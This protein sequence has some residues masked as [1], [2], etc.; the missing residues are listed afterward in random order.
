[1]FHKL[2]L[3]LAALC[4]AVTGLVLIILT[5]VCLFIS[6]SGM[7]RQE[8]DTFL[9]NLNTLY[10]NLASQSSLSHIWVRQAEYNY[11]VSIRIC[12]GEIPL[13]LE[14]LS[15]DEESTALFDRI[16]KTAAA[17]YGI[18]VTATGSIGR[19]ARHEEFSL[20]TSG[21]DTVYASTALIPRSAGTIGVTVF[22]SL[23]IL[24]GQIR[25]QRILFFLADSAALVLLM[26]FFWHFTARIL[27]PLQENRK[28]QMQFV[29]S[30]SHELRSPLTVILSNVAA[31]KNGIMEGDAQFLDTLESEGA[32]MSRLISDMLQLAS[33][34]NHS[35]SIHTS[36]VELDTLLLQVWENYEPLAAAR[37][38]KWNILLPDEPVPH[39]CCDG[40]RIR[41]M[42]SIL[43]DNAFSYT[44]A[45]GCV[46][47]SL[48]CRYARRR[49][50]AASGGS[51]GRFHDANYP[52]A[53]FRILVADNGPGIPDKQKSAVFE[54]FYRADTARRDKS[55]F[56]LG[57]CIAREIARLHRGQLLLTD[58]PGG[59]ATFAIVLPANAR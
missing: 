8:Y 16:A 19:L 45:G 10:Q 3:Q 33:A 27:L 53:A 24:Q 11:Q 30:A 57:L 38:L 40:E 50:T 39:C 51:S 12:D 48:E 29:A 52:P 58:T 22:H 46:S 49:E 1:M 41:Q 13:F 36:D 4:T 2:H 6:E 56:G 35:W 31:V 17:D 42:L 44:P 59:G 9:A 37:N 47:L 14:G 5:L 15:Y 34:D 32:R 7:H 25:R 28:K 20:R 43:I 21:R 54:R 55:H 26:I 18:D 23:A